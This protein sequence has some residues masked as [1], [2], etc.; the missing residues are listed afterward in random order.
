MAQQGQRAWRIGVLD[1]LG[2]DNSEAQARNGAFLQDLQQQLGW[3]SRNVRQTK[4]V[5]D[6]AAGISRATSIVSSGR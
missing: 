1:T 3:T 6:P 2:A 4:F 5:Q